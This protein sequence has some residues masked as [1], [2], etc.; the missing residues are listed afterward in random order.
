MFLLKE[1]ALIL[2]LFCVLQF[3]ALSKKLGKTLQKEIY[4]NGVVLINVK[5]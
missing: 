2:C 4:H 3:V 1:F 5:T